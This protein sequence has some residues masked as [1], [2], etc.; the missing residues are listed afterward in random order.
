MDLKFYLNK[1]LKVDNIE[2]YTLSTVLEIK[3]RYEKFIEK[4][5]GHDPDFPWSNFGDQ[6]TKGKKVGGSNIHTV[7]DKDLDYYDPQYD[8]KTKP[9]PKESD[10]RDK[11]E[12][13]TAEQRALKFLKSINGRN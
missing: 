1:F 6:K 4:S 13:S 12:T 9:R 2:P 5:E 7:G 8:A 10:Y 11:R 3:K